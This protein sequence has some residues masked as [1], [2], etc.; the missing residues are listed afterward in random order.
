MHIDI[1]CGVI[2]LSSALHYKTNILHLINTGIESM[3]PQYIY[4]STHDILSIIHV[5]VCVCATL[6]NWEYITVPRDEPT[7]HVDSCLIL[8]S[9]EYILSLFSCF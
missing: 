6:K 3:F 9:R 1:D 2:F 5:H 8:L 7:V 4:R